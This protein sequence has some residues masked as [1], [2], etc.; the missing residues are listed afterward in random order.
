MVEMKN[1]HR[2]FVGKCEW[3]KPLARTMRRLEDNIRMDLGE[4]G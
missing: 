4:V 1:A 3:K 2:I